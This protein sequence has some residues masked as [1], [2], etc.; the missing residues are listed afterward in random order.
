MVL[1]MVLMLVILQIQG[2]CGLMRKLQERW[3][4]IQ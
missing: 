1:L 3:G 2:F 4:H